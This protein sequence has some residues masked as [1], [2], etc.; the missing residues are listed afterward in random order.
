[1]Q[2]I[3]DESVGIQFCTLFFFYRYAVVIGIGRTG[4]TILP[5]LFQCKLWQKDAQTNELA[6]QMRR[7]LATICRIQIKRG[8]L[9]RLNHFFLYQE[10]PPACPAMGT[11]R[12]L[13]ID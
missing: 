1:M 6:G 13:C 3:T 9:S 5:G 7:N 8:D 2:V 4:D 11:L 10:W 12:L